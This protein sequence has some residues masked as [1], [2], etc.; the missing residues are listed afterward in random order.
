MSEDFSPSGSCKEWAGLTRRPA[1]I[2][3]PGKALLRQGEEGKEVLLLEEGV[4]K[5]VRA[6]R[7]GRERL[8]AFRGRGDI[9]GEM[10]HQSGGVRMAHV[11]AM[12]KCKASAVSVEDF[13]RYVREKGCALSLAEMAIKRLREQ[14]E[15][16]E[17]AVHERLALALHRLAEISGEDQPFSF[18][19]TREELAQYIGVGRKAVTKALELLGPDVVKARRN[20][21]E[22][23]SKEGL[24]KAIIGG[25][26]T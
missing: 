17:G 9:L 5:V 21:I 19:L 24:C 10:A 3:P 15:A 22:V 12:N 6:D 23:V 2:Y 16:Q 1:R 20:R 14:T 25:L 4:V 13:K 8:L 11:W 18:P 7:D 26:G